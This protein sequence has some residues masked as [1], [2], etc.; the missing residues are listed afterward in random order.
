MDFFNFCWV[1]QTFPF[2]SVTLYMNW[3]HLKLTKKCL[4]HKAKIDSY[5]VKV[6]DC[7]KIIRP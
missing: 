5:Y 1:F 4:I 6:C 2:F 3:D 7:I